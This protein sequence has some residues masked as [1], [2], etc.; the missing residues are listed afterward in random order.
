[1]PSES[2]MNNYIYSVI[3]NERNDLGAGC[4][5]FFL[6]LLSV[7]YGIVI[8]LRNGLWDTG[9]LPVKSLPRPVVSVGNITWGGVGKSPL[10]IFLA[11]Y[12]QNKGFKPA[13]LMRGYQGRPTAV[14]PGEV[15]NDE[16]LM[17]RAD[18]PEVPVGVN[19]DRVH[20]AKKVLETRDVDLFL[21]DDGFQRRAVKRD[22]N[23]VVVDATNPFG[24][25]WLIPGGILREPLSALRRADIFVITKTDLVEPGVLPLLSERLRKIQPRALLVTS[26]HAP[27]RVDDLFTQQPNSLSVLNGQAVGVVSSIGDP[28]S[29][30]VMLKKIGAQV[31][32]S[33]QFPDHHWYTVPDIERVVQQCA[34]SRIKVIVT[35]AKDAVKLR[36]FS[37]VLQGQVTCLVLKID[38]QIIEKRD[39]FLSR[40]DRVLQR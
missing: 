36:N 8:F 1:M 38:L 37:A 32:E 18:L 24:S 9:L 20:A 33:F 22:L 12:L 23:I 17:M 35:T 6:Q 13:I 16:A 19:K 2:R 15:N 4:L 27:V 5:R 25:G 26:V 14:T 29:F 10:V 21:L 11:T 40:L 28:K 31:Q 34:A 39:E 7:L 30:S 3:T